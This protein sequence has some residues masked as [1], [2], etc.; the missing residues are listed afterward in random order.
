M[1][2]C[3]VNQAACHGGQKWAFFL[4]KSIQQINTVSGILP[5]IFCQLE[6]VTLSMCIVVSPHTCITC[7]YIGIHFV[8]E[9]HYLDSVCMT[10][11]H[12][13]D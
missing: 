7:L 11:R 10:S 1:D 8:Q 5:E 2:A 3:N 4:C 12:L 13:L 6:V 9:I